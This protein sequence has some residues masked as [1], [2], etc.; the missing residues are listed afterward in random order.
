MPKTEEAK[1][2]EIKAK[3]TSRV[4]EQRRVKTKQMRRDYVY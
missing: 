1:A 2:K 3:W 4:A